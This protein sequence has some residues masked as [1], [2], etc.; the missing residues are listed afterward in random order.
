MSK[1][2]CRIENREILQIDCSV[3][4]QQAI[5]EQLNNNDVTRDN[6]Y[7]VDFQARH[8]HGELA[9]IKVSLSVCLLIE[10]A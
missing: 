10:C 2:T 9:D 1:I 6:K 3:V 4:N 8:D 5:G 7:S